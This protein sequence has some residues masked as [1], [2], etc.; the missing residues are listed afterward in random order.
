MWIPII[1]A[2]ILV[3]LA[4]AQYNRLVTARNLRDEA[5]SA[6]DV[7]LK[8]RHDLVPNLVTAVKAYAGHEQSTLEETVAARNESE[9]V[10]G[11]SNSAAVENALSGKLVQMLALAEAYP[12]L[13]ADTLFRKLMDDLVKVEDELQYARRY[14]NGTVRDLNNLIEQFPSN[15]VARTF[16]FSPGEFFELEPTVRN[17]A[18][19]VNLD[20]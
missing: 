4:I 6:I 2:C 10:D 16:H 19:I 14:F 8:M 1:I 12:D 18:P 20:R 7:L 9:N 17:S 15:L 13:K 3:G 11:V 5:W